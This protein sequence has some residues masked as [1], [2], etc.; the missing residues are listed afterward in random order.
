MDRMDSWLFLSGARCFKDMSS[1]D[2][3][4]ETGEQEKD[5]AEGAEDDGDDEEEND[6]DGLAPLLPKMSVDAPSRGM[7]L[8]RR[9]L[10]QRDD[11]WL[12]MSVDTGGKSLPSIQRLTA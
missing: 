10:L 11:S 1:S 3:E 12:T 9:A 7:P 4:S 5:E 8:N 6:C 2:D